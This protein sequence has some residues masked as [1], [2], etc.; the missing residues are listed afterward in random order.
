MIAVK[1]MGGLGNQMFQYAAG[2]RLA[3]HHK[4]SLLVD[5]SHYDNQ[6]ENE[7]PRFYEM[8][9]FNIK[10]KLTK[11]PVEEV[12]AKTRL[13][14][15]ISFEVIK[16]K[17]LLFDKKILEAPD[18]SLLIGHWAS[19]K[20][21]IDVADQIRQEFIFKDRLSAK[22]QPVERK[23][24]QQNNSVSLQIR[25][26]DFVS[27]KGS[28]NFH[29]TVPLSFYKE[30]TAIIEKKISDP[31]YFVISDDPKWCRANLKGLTKYPMVFV[32]HIPGTGQEDMN[33][34]S[35][36]RHNIIANSTFGWWA[37][38]LNDNPDKVIISP[39]SWFK[40]SAAQTKDILPKSWVKLG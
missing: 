10:G 30:A 15:R 23:I 7:V 4:T 13:G 2:R 29:G 24:A 14:R 17:S 12:G 28:S 22:K 38:W 27:H 5:L 3:L 8:G 19:E 1:L 39:A 16:E 40:D 36:C 21:F 9:C 20:Y 31:H 11:Q 18:N 35:Q 6:P 32:D 33:L 34:M 37:A 26:G 25:R